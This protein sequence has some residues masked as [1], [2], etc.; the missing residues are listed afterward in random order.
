MSSVAPAGTVMPLKTMVE[1]EPFDAAA[2]F[3]SV[4]V[5]PDEAVTEL[6][7]VGTLEALA[8]G[9][10]ATELAAALDAGTEATELPATLDAGTEAMELPATLDA[11]AELPGTLEALTASA[12]EDGLLLLWAAGADQTL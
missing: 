12:R 11:G 10:E 5:Q 8:A 9:T 1:H 6:E 7:L 2:A 4:K 3:A